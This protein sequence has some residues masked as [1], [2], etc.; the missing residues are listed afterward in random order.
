M[1][2]YIYIHTQRGAAAILNHTSAGSVTSLYQTSQTPGTK[3]N[4]TAQLVTK[5]SRWQRVEPE[6][7]FGESQIAISAVAEAIKSNVRRGLQDSSF[8]RAS[9]VTPYFLCAKCFFRDLCEKHQLYEVFLRVRVSKY[10]RL[11]AYMT[12]LGSRR[13]PEQIDNALQI[14]SV[15]TPSV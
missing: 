7:S 4:V 15:R 11:R 9:K 1:C 3:S 5:N 10:S 13:A 12:R 14:L 6:T 2:V 8:Q